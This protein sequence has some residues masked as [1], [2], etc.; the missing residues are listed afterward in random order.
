MLF[1]FKH[2][3]ALKLAIEPKL[4][5]HFNPKLEKLRKENAAQISQIIRDDEQ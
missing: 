1:W 4:A 5:P 3:N 2:P